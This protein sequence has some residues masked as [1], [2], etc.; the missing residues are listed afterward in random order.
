MHIF[1]GHVYALHLL[2]ERSKPLTYKPHRGFGIFLMSGKN[3]W[4]GAKNTW[5]VPRMRGVTRG[6]DFGASEKSVNL[7]LKMEGQLEQKNY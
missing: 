2:G 6:K 4:S 1:V 3:T 7:Q 5:S